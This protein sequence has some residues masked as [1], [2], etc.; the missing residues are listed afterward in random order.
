M[1]ISS[2][3]GVT[4]NSLSDS[5]SSSETAVDIDRPFR[6]YD[7]FVN[8]CNEKWVLA[9]R[10][11][12]QLGHVSPKP[13]AL[14]VFDGGTGDGTILAKVMHG[15]H[16][17]YPT[18]PYFV[19]AK[20]ISLEDVRLCLEKMPDRLAEHPATVLVFTNLY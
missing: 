11:S 5:A 1:A 16:W 7:K 4:S 13:P 17:G 3:E 18:V 20:E 6:F 12:M 14:R 2:S 10:V 15:L 9:D 19:L 8:T